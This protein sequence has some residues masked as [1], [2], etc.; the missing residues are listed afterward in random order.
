MICA[1]QPIRV[2]GSIDAIVVV[3]FTIDFCLRLAVVGFMPPRLNTLIDNDWDDTE[4][5]SARKKNRRVNDDPKMTPSEAIAGMVFSFE[6]AIDI[7]SVVPFYVLLLTSGDHSSSTSF[8]RVCRI[9]RIFKVIKSYG[10]IITVFKRTFT[11]S[12]D[13]LVVMA[14]IV[15][16]AQILFA[17]ILFAFESGTYTINAD[18]PSGAWLREVAGTSDYS[19]SPFDSIPTGMYWAIITLTTVGYGD[20]APVTSAGR[21]IAATAAVFGIICIALP[22]TVIGSN[23]S[24]ELEAYQERQW[25]H[26]RA[27][28]KMKVHF[29]RHKLMELASLKI[30]FAGERAKVGDYCFNDDGEVQL[31]DQQK[32]DLQETF[33]LFDVDGSRKSEL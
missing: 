16:V 9:F 5:R 3:F 22:V 4:E 29:V 25:K 30:M 2:F 7:V 19:V 26:R 13:A 23:F 11:S 32:K 14:L 28:R 6:G 8:I 18:Y 17:C 20:L 15:F 31:T 10:G 21:G 33:K 24:S 12:T 1:K 27:R